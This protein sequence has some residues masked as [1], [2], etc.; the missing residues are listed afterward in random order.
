M[1]TD[2]FHDWSPSQEAAASTV[3]GE[4]KRLHALD[5]SSTRLLESL[6]FVLARVAHA[7]CEIC[8]SETL[9]M[10]HILM[11]L[12]E[13]PPAQAILAVEIAKQR[14]KLVGCGGTYSVSRSL[15]HQT[16]PQ[17]R[18]DLLHA[19]VDVASADGM[20]SEHE[21]EAIGRIATELGFASSIARDLLIERRCLRA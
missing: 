15:R 17:Q 1:T 16:D 13:L 18:L 7:D 10:E 21:V 20:L 3:R 4:L 14:A 8:D 9:E 6:A 5:P 2:A 12:A 19:L 11:R